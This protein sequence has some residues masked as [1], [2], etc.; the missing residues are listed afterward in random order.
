[1]KNEPF[2]PQ[3]L[4]S[5]GETVKEAGR[6]LLDDFFKGV[7]PELKRMEDGLSFVTEADRKS[8]AFLRA[9]LAALVPDAAFIGEESSDAPPPPPDRPFWA[10]DPLD[11]T[12]AFML[13]MP[14]WGVSVGYFGAGGRPAMGAIYLPLTRQLYLGTPERSEMNGAM[15]RACSE[16]TPRTETLFMQSDLHLAWEYNWPGKVRGLGSAV[17]HMMYAAGGVA[18]G[19]VTQAFIW[20]VGAALS[21]LPGAGAELRYMDGTPVDA[22]ALADRRIMRQPA[23]ASHPGM[24]GKIRESMVRRTAQGR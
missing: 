3:M 14:S 23:I 12:H 16:I 21:I 18:C 1:M 8:Q 17:A 5:L 13:G 24:F 4:S 10:V 19:S 2:P 20:D 9:E 11:G 15:I 7:R 22:M 6:R